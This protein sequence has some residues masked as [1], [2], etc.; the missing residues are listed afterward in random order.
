[1]KIFINKMKPIHIYICVRK[2]LA[3][4]V[5]TYTICIEYNMINKNIYLYT[6]KNKNKNINISFNH[7]YI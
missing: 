3:N 1:M 2:L 7:S 4:A 6:Y 5:Y